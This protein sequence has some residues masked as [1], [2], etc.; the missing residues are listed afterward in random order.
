MIT[1]RDEISPF[2][3]Q[4]G[5]TI[6]ELMHPASHGCTA[7]SLA[8]AVVA[9]GSRTLLHRHQRSEEFYH[10]LAGRGEVRVGDE[11]H[12]VSAGDTVCIPPGT[13][14]NIES[15]GEEA[16]VFLCCCSPAYSHDDTELLE[17]A[18]PS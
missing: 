1:R 7:Q 10:I 13:P 14:H 15:Q 8:E 18:G 2:V 3:T 4:D 6:R 16:L 5:S 12:P 9:P 17:P 11:R